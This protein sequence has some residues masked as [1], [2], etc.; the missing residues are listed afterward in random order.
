MNS[1]KT[2]ASPFH[3]GEQFIQDK[4]GVRDKMERF[5]RQVI[6]EYMP[7]QHQQFYAQLPFVFVG[8]A[9]QKG[10]PW[11]SILFNQ[12]GFMQSSDNQHLQINTLPVAGDPLND[13]LQPGNRLGLLG[14][15]LETR[16]RNRL[17]THI[18]QLTEN[19]LELSVDQAFGNCPQYI[20][21]R[22]LHTVDQDSMSPQQ[23]IDL[24]KFDQQAMDLISASDT[25]FVA[26]YVANDSGAISEGADVSHR[27][28][29]PGFIR[30]DDNQSLTIPD[31]LG[32]FHFNT[33]G[34]FLVNNKAGLLFID[35]SNGHLLTLTGT[36]EILWDS[37]DTE[38]FTGAE[39]LWRFHMDHGR[40]L[41]NVLPLRW[42]L[43]DY[44]PNTVLTGSWREAEAA[45]NADLLKNSWQSYRIAKIVSESSIIKSFYL[46]PPADQHPQFKPGQFI[47]LKTKI[48]GTEQIRTY[49][50][51]S[52][53]GDDL[54]RI[55]IKHEQGNKQF[56]AGVFSSFMHDQIN[57]GS[58]IDAKAPTGAFTF[59]TSSNRT[60]VLIAAGIGITP[61]I[62]MARNVLQQAIRT[63]SIQPLIL[64]CSARNYAQRAFYDELN[65]LT[66]NS[67]GY[68]QVYWALS[69][70]E[71]HLRPGIDFQHTG[72]IDSTWLQTLLPESNCNIYLCGPDSFMQSLYNNLREY[73][74]MDTHIFAEAFGPASLVRDND[75]AQQL[76]I[77]NE[78]IVTFSESQLEQAW[79]QSDGNLLE[80]AEA[81]GLTPAY[82]CRSGQCGS[83]KVKLLTGSVT[84]PNNISVPIND[85]E[86]LLCCAMPAAD[87]ED[88]IA[89]LKIQL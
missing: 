75:S 49:T 69:Q 66:K 41:K 65:E 63:R 21:N 87:A 17:S 40:W 71:T 44:S 16:R 45:K 37:P 47:T 88:T 54:Y 61:M 76:P 22:T 79:S 19:G 20:Q 29:K 50:V 14:I 34:N 57:V 84:Y 32:N 15:E 26:S 27:G 25:F 46:Q 67:G 6:R 55:S 9:D 42:N 28:G 86:V 80:F 5:G 52:A 10:W 35:F 48:N 11:A 24:V 83:C 23:T 62:A 51:S 31:Y 18:H 3:Q 2:K 58:M 12:P 81:H 82:G 13:S 1:T 43:Q 30:V 64:I 73:G 59:D 85:D 77:A 56:P 39:R 74:I 38:F 89:Q 33:L 4:L 8:H 68:I 78:A 72:R 7:E 70:P 60:A 53:P 36:V